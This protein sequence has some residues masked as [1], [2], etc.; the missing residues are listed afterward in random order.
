MITVTTSLLA[1]TIYPY[2][3]KDPSFMVHR[4]EESCINNSC[5]KL[6]TISDPGSNTGLIIGVSVTAAVVF[7]LAAICTVTVLG[8]CCQIQRRKVSYIV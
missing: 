1:V 6:L 7:V 5:G 8:V 2:M 3:L 4:F